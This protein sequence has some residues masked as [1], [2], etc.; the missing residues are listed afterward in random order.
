[1]TITASAMP[2]TSNGCAAMTPRSSNIPTARKN[3]PSRIDR[4]GSTSLS[5]SWRYGDSASIT[6]ATNAPSATDSPSAC[7]S[8]DAPTTVNSP[9]TTNSSRSPSRPISR[10]IGL[11]THR[12]AS[13]SPTT[14]NT[15]YNAS[16]HPPGA[17][18]SGATRD[19]AAISVIIGT[20]DRSW[21]SRIEKA[22]S[23]CGVLRSPSPRS[24]GS[25][26]A[27]DDSPSG[28]PIANAAARL[29]PSTAWMNRL[30]AIPHSN[31][32]ASPS[33]KISLR[34]RHSRLGL[35]SSPTTNSS[36]AMPSSVTLA[37][38]SGSSIS[39]STCG[40]ISAPAT[41]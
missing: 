40:P 27:V 4:N 16:V 17:A 31:T 32:C 2:T 26:C 1:M 6:P 38:A 37:S 34:N 30:S 36:S 25:T 29:T 39:P 11:M 12:P 33:P 19:I 7:I 15:V 20:I 14:A 28:S 8:A 22:R 10:N 35:S 13:T 3:S 9:A 41:I 24:I 5:S 21:N 23:P 18:G